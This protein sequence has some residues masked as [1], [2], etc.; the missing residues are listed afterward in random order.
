MRHVW[1]ILVLIAAAINLAPLV[2]AIS[3]ERMAAAYGVDLSDPSLQILMRHRAMLF[4]VVGGLL[5]AMAFRPRLRAVGYVA[6]FSSMLSFL[7]IAWWVGGYAAPIQRVILLDV[8]GIAALAGAA[9]VQAVWLRAAAAS[10]SG[11]G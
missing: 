2:G 11:S 7:L 1:T 4:G 10:P 9:L 3:A 5:A 8:I 6:G